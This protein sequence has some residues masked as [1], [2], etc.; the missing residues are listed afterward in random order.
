VATMATG[1]GVNDTRGE[2]F[3]ALSAMAKLGLRERTGFGQ[4][5]RYFH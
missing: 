2:S 4:V 1:T 3:D 5:S